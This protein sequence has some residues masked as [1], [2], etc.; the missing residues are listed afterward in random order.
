MWKTVLMS[1]ML[2]GD[3]FDCMKMEICGIC[4]IGLGAKVIVLTYKV[5]HGTEPRYLDHL[6]MCQVDTHSDLLLPTVL[7]YPLSD[8]QLLVA[9]PFWLLQLRSGMHC[10]TMSFQHHP[11]THFGIS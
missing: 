5:L 8:C 9:K 4:A 3:K 1:G 6:L 10:L 11:L 7:L 2:I